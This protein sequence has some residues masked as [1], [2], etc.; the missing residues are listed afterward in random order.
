M[1]NILPNIP[2][3]SPIADS[4]GLLTPPWSGFFQ[5]LFLRVGK[6][7]ALTNTELAA[8][9]SDSSAALQKQVDTLTTTVATLQT[10]VTLG[11][12]GLGQG[13]VL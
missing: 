7:S 5:F 8:I 12:D 3:G 4:S 9:H 6:S 2:Y 1:A 13:P 11:L 10:Q